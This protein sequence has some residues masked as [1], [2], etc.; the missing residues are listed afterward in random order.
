MSP[1]TNSY[2]S[3][4]LFHF[5]GHS[6]P[7]DDSANYENLKKILKQGCVSHPPH[8]VSYGKVSHTVNYDGNLKDETFIKPTVTCFADIPFDA[9]SI[10]IKKYRNFGLAFSKTS[11]VKQG[12]RPVMYFPMTTNDFLTTRGSALLK[13]IE[14]AVKGFDIE[15][16]EKADSP[17]SRTGG[18]GAMPSNAGEAIDQIE[19]MIMKDFLSFIKPYN[20]DLQDDHPENFYMEREWRKYGNVKFSPSD[21]LRVV[22]PNSFASIMLSDFPEYKD[23]LYNF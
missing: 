18:F 2:A 23:K 10:H 4:E 11:L 22:L 5:V 16:I 20:S 19:S 15:V 14:A 3:H 9:L 8:D 21:I 6:S 1:L 12:A 17:E 7:S 13:S